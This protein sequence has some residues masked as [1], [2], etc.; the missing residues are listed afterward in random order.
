MTSFLSEWCIKAV[1]DGT[2]SDTVNAGVFQGYLPSPT[3]FILH[4]NHILLTSNFHCY[5]DNS[6]GDAY[7]TIYTNISL[8]LVLAGINM[9]LKERLPWK[10]PEEKK[11]FANETAGVVPKTSLTPVRTFVPLS[12]S[13]GV[14]R[15]PPS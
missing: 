9:C 1:V 3:L 7:Y 10:V 4:L 13:Q 12:N 8:Q 11:K 5:G 6:T 2:W 15:I 14:E